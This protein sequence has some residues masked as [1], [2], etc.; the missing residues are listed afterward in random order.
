MR[1]AQSPRVRG[2]SNAATRPV[3]QSCGVAPRRHRPPGSGSLSGAVVSRPR[4]ARPH[5]APRGLSRRGPTGLGSARLWFTARDRYPS[6]VLSSWQRV[7]R[8][9]SPITL[10]RGLARALDRAA[11]DCVVSWEYG[12]ATW[13]ALAWSRRHRKPLVIF[14]ELTPWSDEVL[15]SGQLRLHRL[16]APRAAG[17][18]VA[19][20]RGRARLAGLGVDPGRVEVALQS[21]EIE[22]WPPSRRGPAARRPR[23][24]ALGGAPRARQESRAPAGGV[25][26]GR[27]R[28][29]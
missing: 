8:G 17:F 6:E 13:R 7:R 26:H 11:A 12:P 15:S 16:I 19:S 14:S 10:P 29:R 2:P 1:P 21:A 4:R 24:H 20:T 23:A 3:R 5:R 28:V 18:V 27:L 22:A 25:R 9:R